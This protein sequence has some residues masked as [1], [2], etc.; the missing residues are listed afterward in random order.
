MNGCWPES[1]L[2]DSGPVSATGEGGRAARRSQAS[3]AAKRP[4]DVFVRAGL[5]SDW[6]LRRLPP[7]AQ[8]EKES[9]M[10]EI[11]HRPSWDEYHEA[12]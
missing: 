12:S 5:P 8:V 2:R 3:S 11:D 4:V 6:A 7:P 10:T 1:A 9:D